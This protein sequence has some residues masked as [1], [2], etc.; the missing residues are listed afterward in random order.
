MAVKLTRPS[1]TEFRDTLDSE[2][3]WVRPFL[4]SCRIRVGGWPLPPLTEAEF[5]FWVRNSYTVKMQLS[6]A[7]VKGTRFLYGI[8]GCTCVSVHMCKCACVCVCGLWV[9]V[10]VCVH[11]S[12]QYNSYGNDWLAI[13]FLFRGKL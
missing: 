9:W 3:E 6:A 7:T 11:V 8:C 13:Y 1:P 4:I 12:A 5:R 10:W 2:D